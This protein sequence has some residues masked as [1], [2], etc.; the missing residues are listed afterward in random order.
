MHELLS[1]SSFTDKQLSLLPAVLRKRERERK[2]EKESERER[3][4]RETKAVS[5]SVHLKTTN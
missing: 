3:E 2:R 5:S 1:R 4:K